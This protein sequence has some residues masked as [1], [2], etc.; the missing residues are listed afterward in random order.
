M[1]QQFA[2]CP[3]PGTVNRQ[4]RTGY[5]T[6]SLPLHHPSPTVRFQLLQDFRAFQASTG[7]HGPSV[8]THDPMEDISHSNHGSH[9]GNS[10]TPPHS[11]AD[12][13]SQTQPSEAASKIPCSRLI[14]SSIYHS[15]RGKKIK[16]QPQYKEE[17]DCLQFCHCPQSLF[18]PF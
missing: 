4:D 15:K 6:S 9:E 12:E 3:Q 5:K 16:D 1:G 17:F 13:L 8:R 11:P 18:C 14:F 7:S 2:C 10:F